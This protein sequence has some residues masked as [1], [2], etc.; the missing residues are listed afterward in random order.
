MSSKS[1][2]RMTARWS[3]SASRA[4]PMRALLT[5]ACAAGLAVAATTAATDAKQAATNAS[6]PPKAAAAA[7]SRAPQT[8]QEHIVR[9]DAVAIDARGTRVTGL[10][11][12]DFDL[13]ED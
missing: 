10:T 11:A 1:S 8:P 2:R 12:K 5:A 13:I 9:I 3:V 4:R 6:P 7:D